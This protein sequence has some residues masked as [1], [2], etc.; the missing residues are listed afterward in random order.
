[1]ISL[2]DV[3]RTVVRDKDI[4]GGVAAI[5]FADEVTASLV[6]SLFLTI[7]ELPTIP[8][9]KVVKRLKQC[10]CLSNRLIFTGPTLRRETRK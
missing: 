6:V 4:V 3:N 2:Q 8:S 1:L 9:I 7:I 5:D 10:S